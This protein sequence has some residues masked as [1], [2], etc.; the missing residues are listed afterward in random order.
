MQ[1]KVT[2]FVAPCFLLCSSAT[3]RK[4]SSGVLLLLPLDFCLSASDKC[5]VLVFVMSST[6]DALKTY[7]IQ[8]LFIPDWNILV[9][10][11]GA[12]KPNYWLF[13]PINMQ[14]IRKWPISTK[15]VDIHELCQFIMLLGFF[16]N[17]QLISWMNSTTKSIKIDSKWI[18][19]KP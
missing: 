8:N 10:M 11:L 2:P 14:R 7:N 17:E 12:S 16:F 18:R 4:D 13:V 15:P 5:S 1:I 3:P 6:F 19:M 9:K